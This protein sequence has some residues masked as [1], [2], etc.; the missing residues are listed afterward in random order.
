MFARVLASILALFVAVPFVLSP[1]PA[2]AQDTALKQDTAL[3]KDAT[4]SKEELDQILAPIA[5]YPD[6]LLSNVLVAATYPLEVVQA[7]R[8]IEEPAHARLKGNAL[9]QALEAQDWDPSVKS[10]TQFPDVLAMMNEQ[11][12]WTQKLGDA[13]LA[14]ETD[15][16]DRIQFLRNKA[17]EA[18]HLKSNAHQTVTTRRSGGAGYIYIEP[19]EPEIIYVPVY[20]PAVYGD[21]WYPDYPPYYWPADGAYEDDY[22][23]GA[24]VTIFPPLW[25]WWAPRW[26]GHYIHVNVN[27]YNRFSHHRRRITSNRWRHDAYHRR[28]V[29]YGNRDGRKRNLDF[30]GHDGKQVLKPSVERRRDA[31]RAG[32]RDHKSGDQHRALQRSGRGSIR[33]RARKKITRPAS[34]TAA[35]TARRQNRDGGHPPTGLRE[36]DL[37]PTGIRAEAAP[38]ERTGAGEEHVPAT[39]AGI[40]AVPSIEAA[41][42]IAAEPSDAVVVA[43][44]EAAAAMM[45]AAANGVGI[46]AAL[47]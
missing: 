7:A 34:S 47:S 2:S 4:F 31:G 15:V 22:Y 13:F 12:D 46:D 30:R 10:L 33:R 17:E 16:M 23:W 18:G 6:D 41:V 9:T 45:E 40:A 29:S 35:A 14:S 42:A 36:G 19:A 43:V 11:L 38:R 1:V 5:L 24:G 21:W 28:G 27:R 39:A 26:G 32:V 20:E 8:W 44:I 3:Q 25:G 37:P